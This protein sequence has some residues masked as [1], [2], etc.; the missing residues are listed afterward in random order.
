MR[1]LGLCTCML[2]RHTIMESKTESEKTFRWVPCCPRSRFRS[3]IEQTNNL[4]PL[5]P[6]NYPKPLSLRKGADIALDMLRG[7]MVVIDV[8]GL[9]RHNT[10]TPT[11]PCRESRAH[12][13][14]HALLQTHTLCQISH[15]RTLSLSLSLPN[16]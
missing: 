5:L 12:A 13:D 9:Q 2:C 1:K 3:P 10:N 4:F 14:A 6:V 16:L 8:L 15:D 7:P 11:R